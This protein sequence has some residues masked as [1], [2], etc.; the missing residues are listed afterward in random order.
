MVEMTYGDFDPGA[1]ALVG[2]WLCRRLEDGTV[3]WRRIT[4]TSRP[5]HR[6]RLRLQTRP[7]PQ[8][9]LHAPLHHKSKPSHYHK[10]RKVEN[11][12]IAA[13]SKL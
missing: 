6:H 13:L 9:A 12:I 5:S 3:M 11:K 7:I 8:M 4:E 2:A 1:K 10:L